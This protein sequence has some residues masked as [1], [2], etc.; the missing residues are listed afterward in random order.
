MKRYAIFL[1]VSAFIATSGAGEPKPADRSKLRER[2]S[3]AFPLVL[4]QLTVSELIILDPFATWA[5]PPPNKPQFHKWVVA[6]RGSPATVASGRSLI[7]SMR[8]IVD[9]PDDFASAC[10]EPHHAAVLTA[11]SQRVDIVT[12]FKCSQYKVYDAKGRLV[13]G[14]SF[15]TVSRKEEARWNAVFA[16][17]KF[18]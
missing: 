5:D 11:G 8:A 15:T 4:E 1:L 3:E 17:A 6:S 18:P 10:F 14:G 16:G 13:W 2:A 12:C 7:L 9:H